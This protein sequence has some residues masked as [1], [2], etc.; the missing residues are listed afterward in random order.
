MTPIPD[1]VFRDY[2]AEQQQAEQ[3]RA[4]HINRVMAA[5]NALLRKQQG[6]AVLCYKCEQK[7]LEL[8]LW[9]NLDKGDNE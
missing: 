9:I 8:E 2:E 3:L 1:V 4:E 5:C 7:C 6:C